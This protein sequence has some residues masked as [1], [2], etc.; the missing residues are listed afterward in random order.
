MSKQN[1]GKQC[2]V[3]LGSQIFEIK[4][5]SEERDQYLLQAITFYDGCLVKGWQDTSQVKLIE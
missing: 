1:V 4:K 3:G 2:T 5:Y